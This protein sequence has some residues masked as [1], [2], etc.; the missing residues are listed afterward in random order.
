MTYRALSWRIPNARFS[1]F[2]NGGKAN[3]ADYLYVVVVGAILVWG[4]RSVKPNHKI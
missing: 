4:L 3:E 1:Q 2:R